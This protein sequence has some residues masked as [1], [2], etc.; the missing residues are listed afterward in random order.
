MW[1]ARGHPADDQQMQP[2]V[3]VW[4]PPVHSTKGTMSREG[5]GCPFFS[6]AT[7]LIHGY[8]SWV[9]TCLHVSDSSCL[10]QYLLLCFLCSQAALRV[11]APKSVSGFLCPLSGPHLP[12]ERLRARH[13]HVLVHWLLLLV[14]ASMWVM[15]VG[16]HTINISLLHGLSTPWDQG[17]SGL[18]S[19]LLS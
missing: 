16:N 15:C 1:P 10:C 14:L 3:Q 13:Y 12:H 8:Y 17:P 9:Q 2:T 19:P 18:C 5:H 11:A 4:W 6:K 7:Q